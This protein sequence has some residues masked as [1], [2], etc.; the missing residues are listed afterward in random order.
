MGSRLEIPFYKLEGD[1]YLVTDYSS[2]MKLVYNEKSL[3]IFIKKTS[4]L[5]QMRREALID[6]HEFLFPEH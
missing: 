3:G 2:E 6:V 4:N 1:M 5:V